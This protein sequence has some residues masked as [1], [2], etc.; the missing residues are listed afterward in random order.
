MTGTHVVISIIIAYLLGAIPFGYWIGKFIYHKDLLTLGSGNIG[1]TNTFRILGKI[2]GTVVFVLD[3]LKGTAAASMAYVWGPLPTSQHY[4]VLII[5]VVAVIGH[6]FSF[7]LNFKGGKGV[8]TSLGILLAYSPT[9]FVWS[10]CFFVF[11]LLISSM[12]SVASILGFLMSS[13]LFWVIDDTILAT[14]CSILM[15][16]VVYLHRSNI[17]RIIHGTENTIKFGLPYWIKK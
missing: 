13:I 15:L 2:P 14:V 7:W 8:A 10:F 1:T 6:T 5:G 16:F 9:L 4:W 11:G 17:Q 3:I 12:V